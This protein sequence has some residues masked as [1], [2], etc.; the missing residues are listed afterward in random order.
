M[1]G[2][3]RVFADL[4]TLNQALARHWQN[5]AAQ[6]V[7][8]RGAFHVALAGGST[9]RQFYQALAAPDIAGDLPWAQTHCYFGDERCVPR[10]HADSNYRMAQQ[11]LLTQVA[12]PASQV[13]PMYDPAYSPEQNAARYADLLADQLPKGADGR[14]MFD[15]ILLGM[16]GDGHTASLFPETAILT[17]RN[18]LVAAQYVAAQQSWRISLTYPVINAAQNVVLLVVGAAKAEI[19][20]TIAAASGGTEQ[21]P[22]QRVNPAGELLWFLDQEAACLL[23][24]DQP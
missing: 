12:I 13:Y 6:A 17:E 24:A 15:L 21:F 3:L 18:K 8:A 16:G 9:P 4:A 5:L 19:V 7:A 20:A 14:A 2:R 22:V 11:T 23:A 1:N 10:D